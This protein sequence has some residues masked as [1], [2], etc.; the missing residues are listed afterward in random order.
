[1]SVPY[2][3]G[4]TFLIQLIRMKKPSTHSKKDGLKGKKDLVNNQYLMEALIRFFFPQFN[5][6]SLSGSTFKSEVTRYLH[7]QVDKTANLCFDQ[8]MSEFD[9]AVKTSF[10][11]VLP[12]MEDLVE[13]FVYTGEG[14]RVEDVVKALLQTIQ[15]DTTIQ[16]TDVFYYGKAVTKAELLSLKE[17]VLEPFLLALWHFIVTQRPKNTYG[18]QTFDKWMTKPDTPGTSWPYRSSIGSA[19]SAVKVTRSRGTLFEPPLETPGPEPE[20]T[21]K[22]DGENETGQCRDEKKS[23]A[24][25]G[26]QQLFVN[27]G[28]VNNFYN[29]PGGI[30]IAHLEHFNLNEWWCKNDD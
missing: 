28:V 13:K 14:N 26:C 4:G 18:Q 19:Y 29:A 23:R 9:R 7:C 2:L 1:M 17:I 15:E 27:E 6:S 16:S 21:G 8:D 12:A 24:A 22:P 20:H 10:S 5:L 25:Q 3:C 30:Q 11:A